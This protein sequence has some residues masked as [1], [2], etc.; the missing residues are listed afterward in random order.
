MTFTPTF[1]PWLVGAAVL[2]T[3]LVVIAIGKFVLWW[4]TRD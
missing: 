3:V 2:G 4:V 1:T